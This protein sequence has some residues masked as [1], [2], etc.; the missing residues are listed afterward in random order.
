MAEEPLGPPLTTTS[1]DL[2]FQTEVIPLFPTVEQWKPCG[3]PP[4]EET[5]NRSGWGKI[6]EQNFSTLAKFEFAH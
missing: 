6:L 2:A 1:S 5:R 4:R 3:M